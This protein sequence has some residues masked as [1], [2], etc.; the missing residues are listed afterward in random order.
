MKCELCDV[1]LGH[2]VNA[3][4]HFKGR[5]HANRKRQLDFA[6]ADGKDLGYYALYFRT[7][8]SLFKNL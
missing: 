2:P 6:T 1:E 3:E 7:R 4:Q 8:N 5:K